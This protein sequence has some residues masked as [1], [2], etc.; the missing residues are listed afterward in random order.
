MS[1]EPA[2]IT[3]N[4]EVLSS[5]VFNADG[6]IPVIVIDLE[7]EVL[8]LAYMNSEALKRTLESG[9]TWFYS[10]SRR[11]YWA[12][13]ET[14]G[15]IQKV[16]DIRSDCDRDTL[17]VRVEQV[18]EGACHTGAYSCF[19]EVVGQKIAAGE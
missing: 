1:N 17:L 14:S 15:N 13:G 2:G 5:L 16:I 19:F 10:R 7:G 9:R 11:Q 12:K 18:G 6:L 8:M 3:A 4:P